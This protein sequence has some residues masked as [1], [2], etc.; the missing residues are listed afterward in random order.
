MRIARIEITNFIGLRKFAVDLPEP[1]LLV[2]GPNGSGKSSLLE[3]VRFALLGDSPRVGLKKELPLLLNDGAKDGDVCITIDGRMLS[4]SV[5]TGKLS[6]DGVGA[7]DATPVDAL[8]YV[9]GAQRF[10]DLPVAE[11]RRFLFGLFGVAVNPSGVADEL[12]RIGH[13]QERIERIKPLLRSGFDAAAKE[14]ASLASEARGAWKEITGEVYGSVKA[15]TWR[16]PD[17]EQPQATALPDLVALREAYEQARKLAS[18]LEARKAAAV[19]AVASLRLLRERAAKA[20]ELHA[21]LAKIEAFQPMGKCPQCSTPLAV[22]E[23]SLVVATGVDSPDSPE[24]TRGMRDAVR[25][26]LRDAEQAQATLNE[27]EPPTDDEIGHAHAAEAAARSRLEEA[28]ADHHAAEAARK[29]AAEQAKRAGRAK[30]LHTQV[31]AW[32][33]LAADLSPDGLP[34]AML[35]RA[36]GPFNERLM[37][38]HA[39]TGWPLVQVAPDMGITAGGRAYGLLSESERWRADAVLSEAISHAAGLKLLALDRFDVLDLPS[40]GRFVRWLAGLADEY[41]TIIAAGT[42][43]AEPADLPGKASAVWLGEASP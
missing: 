20:G 19:Q 7:V 18:M 43:K 16:A 25:A 39:A 22:A 26:A 37:A 41:D 35:A 4:R 12:K 14:A 40:R 3:A 5:R 42:L 27:I 28:E 8:T 6:I 38:S 10:A 24:K 9:L 15:E 13:D 32:T 34:A 31:T 1:V 33:K 36:L 2:A 23:G 11:R 29:D 17:V 30:E 21:D